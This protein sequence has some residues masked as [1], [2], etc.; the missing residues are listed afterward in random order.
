VWLFSSGP[1]RAESAAP[2]AAHHVMVMSDRA[3]AAIA[4]P[5]QP[6]ADAL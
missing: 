6:R 1:L 3:D 4:A 5:D 2:H